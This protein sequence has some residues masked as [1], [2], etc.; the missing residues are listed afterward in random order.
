MTDRDSLIETMARATVS[1]RWGRAI[2]SFGNGAS[3]ERWRNHDREMLAAALD[4]LEAAGLK[5]ERKT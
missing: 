4:A 1:W 3:S 2:D 5:I